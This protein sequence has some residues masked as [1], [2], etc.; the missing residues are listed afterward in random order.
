VL[1]FSIHKPYEQVRE[2]HKIA[3]WMTNL[4]RL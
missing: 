2:R 4:M 3:M 1:V